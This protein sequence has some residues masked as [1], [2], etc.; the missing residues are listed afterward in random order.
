MGSS[1]RR[2]GFGPAAGAGALCAS[3]A[4]HAVLVASI[5]A[6]T[7]GG[8][9]PGEPDSPAPAELSRADRCAI[10]AAGAE[11]LRAGLCEAPLAG[12]SIECRDAPLRSLE[13]ELIRCRGRDGPEPLL[14]DE[15]TEGAEVALVDPEELPTE[16]EADPSALDEEMPPEEE[17]RPEPPEVERGAQ[18][19]ETP[20]SEDDGERPDDARFL[21]EHDRVVDREQVA[22]GSTDE[23]VERPGPGEGEGARD[24]DAP[25]DES[26]EAEAERDVDP[27]AEPDAQPEAEEGAGEGEAGETRGDSDPDEGEGER[28]LAMREPPPDERP[29]PREG[30]EDLAEEGELPAIGEGGLPEL[31]ELLDDAPPAGESELRGGAGGAPR[32][33]AAPD[34]R[35]T[36]EMLAEALGGGGGSVDHLEGVPEGE[37]TALN[38]AQWKHASFFNR[39]KREVARDWEPQAVLRE[40]DPD[41]STYGLRARVTVVRVTLARDGA[42][43][44]VGV[45]RGSGVSALDEE[46]VRAFEAAEPFPNPPAEL[47]EDGGDTLGFHFG[48]HFDIRSR[49]GGIFRSR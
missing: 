26:E 12:R 40:R 22:R 11:A 30:I 45:V 1:P 18:V 10:E 6:F 4:A 9:D 3:F 31:E 8:E 47:V 28:E 16:P 38:T 43:E 32:D 19:V 33:G 15:S 37:E 34:L 13:L 35:P 41:G 44:A 25:A 20:E 24:D 29:G 48:F 17:E 14:D 49:G 23:M 46:A 42:L 39:V 2:R 5:V 7:R 21:A 36:D 27:D